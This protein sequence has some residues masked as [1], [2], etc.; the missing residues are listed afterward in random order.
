[1]LLSQELREATRTLHRDA[2]RAGVMGRLLRRVASRE[3]YVAMLVAL[4]EIYGALENALDSHS[5]NPVLGAL[6]IP[7]L[8]R[9]A[10]LRSDIAAL[11]GL[12][13]KSTAPHPLA[14]EYAEH[15][16]V[17]AV[18]HSPRL[19][20]HAWLRYLG[21]LN[22]GQV[23]ARLVRE[24]LGVTE[25]C[26]QF[27][28]FSFSQPAAE[29]A[30]SWKAALDALPLDESTQQAIVQEARNGFERHI[31]LFTALAAPDAPPDVA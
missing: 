3:E 31:A 24:G 10:A 8:A 15:L 9:R 4:A 5:G 21:D 1:M 2:E 30:Q 27:Y 7:G 12:G 19:V 20:A 28:A 6:L 26:T 18:R 29:V 13:I 11:E 17:L 22:G 23:V 14:T 25:D 16:G